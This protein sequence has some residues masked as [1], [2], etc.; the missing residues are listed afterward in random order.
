MWV[1]ISCSDVVSNLLIMQLILEITID[2]QH[3][4]EHLGRRSYTLFAFGQSRSAH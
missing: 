1:N 4:A 2:H 3:C